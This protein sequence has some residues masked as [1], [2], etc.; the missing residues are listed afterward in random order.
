MIN[1]LNIIHLLSA[2]KLDAG[3]AESPCKDENRI[4]LG[5]LIF[6]A[7]K[8]NLPQLN[9]LSE[10]FKVTIGM[11]LFVREPKNIYVWSKLVTKS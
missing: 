1:L 8:Q 3:L 5:F 7:K 4:K 9:T 11:I 6:Q 2:Q 10:I